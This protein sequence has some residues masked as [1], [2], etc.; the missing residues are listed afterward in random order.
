MLAAL[1]SYWFLLILILFLLFGV[2]VGCKFGK[3]QISRKVNAQ[4]EIVNVAEGAVFALFGLLIA[5]SFSGAYDRY[6]GRVLHIIQESTAYETAYL[7][8]DLLA[9]ETQKG[10]RDGFRQYL[11]SR[12][13]I[14]QNANL[15]DN[16]K[17]L[18]NA[19]QKSFLI[20]IQLWNQALAACK[21][22][23]NDTV[24][25]LFI[26]GVN[27]MFDEAEEGY[28]LTSVHPP[29]I[30]LL[31]LLG[32]ATLGALLAGY[33]IAEKNSSGFLHILSYIMLTSFT[34]FII[35]NLEYPRVGKIHI[36]HFD[37]M[38]TTVRSHWNTNN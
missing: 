23:A 16:D 29:R 21:A 20:K 9:P 24:T 2:F 12:L 8:I 30:I 31:L 34:I 35:I 38:I 7:R 18:A 28:D 6:E 26:L 32:L 10:L 4:L 3:W 17:N 15:R 1:T 37:R 14:Y 25:E 13:F 19:V 5:F 27:K 36:S 33:S 11:D 22:T